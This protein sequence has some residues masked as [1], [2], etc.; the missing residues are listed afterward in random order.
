MAEIY[1]PT[2]ALQAKEAVIC[3]CKF[4]VQKNWEKVRTVIGVSTRLF[5]KKNQNS[6]I[7][8]ANE[9][10]HYVKKKRTSERVEQH[11][12]FVADFIT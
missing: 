4:N 9:Y 8:C 11:K 6:G 12:K 5:Y 1:I 7:E 2:H 10:H 3:E